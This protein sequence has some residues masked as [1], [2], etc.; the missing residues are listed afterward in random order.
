M[1]LVAKLN[2]KKLKKKIDVAVGDLIGYNRIP[3]SGFQV[4]TPVDSEFLPVD[5]GFPLVD[6]CW[7]PDSISGYV[8]PVV[9][10]RFELVSS[11]HRYRRYR[12]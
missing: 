1:A 3:S 6:Y 2:K 12:S 9:D 7:I 4:P 11:A 5:S 8:F 10:S